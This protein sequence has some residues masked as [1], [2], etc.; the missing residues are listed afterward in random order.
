MVK[1][2]WMHHEHNVG[3]PSL[4][5]GDL[6]TKELSK[7]LS[8]LEFYKTKNQP[9]LTIPKAGQSFQLNVSCFPRFGSLGTI[10]LRF[11]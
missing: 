1:L 10:K 11:S 3:L 7:E 6:H 5:R 8:L 9:G 2:C 4:L